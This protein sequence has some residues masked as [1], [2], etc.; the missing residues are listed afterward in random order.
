MIDLTD[1]PA[2][3]VGD[4]A[5]IISNIREA[6]NSVEATAKQLGTIP[7]EVTS[8]LGNRIKRIMID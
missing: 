4:E 6:P 3:K 5:C 7:Y 2:A 8:V 1:I